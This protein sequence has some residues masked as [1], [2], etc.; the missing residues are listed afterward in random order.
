MQGERGVRAGHRLLVH[1]SWIPAAVLVCAQL[2]AGTFGSRPMAASVA[3]GAAATAAIVGSLVLHGLAHAGMARR[4][5]LAPSRTTIYPFGEITRFETEPEAPADEAVVA[6]AGILASLALGG[7]CLA[8]ATFAPGV[9]GE[10][11]WAVGAANVALGGLNLLPGP[12]LDGGRFARAV[13]WARSGDRALAARRAVRWDL[14]LGVTMVAAG[15]GIV[16]FDPY[17]AVGWS[18]LWLAL[19]GAFVWRT[20]RTERREARIFALTDGYTAGS[21][22]HAFAGRIG[23]DD[24]IPALDGIFAVADGGRLAGIASGAAAGRVARDAMIPWSSQLSVTADDPLRSALERMAALQADAVVVLDGEGVVR[25][26]LSKDG[27]RA[28]I[29]GGG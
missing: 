29:S 12:P 7:A 14:A 19:V 23:P 16:T 22:A 15:V 11:L 24:A 28:N 25:G 26:V 2:A 1:P 9:I 8:G 4:R 10:L 21:W 5:G 18:G 27:V 20:A 17:R 3:L 6:G 13:S